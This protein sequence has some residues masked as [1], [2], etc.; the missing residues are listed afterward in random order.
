MV[1]VMIKLFAIR[2]R[3]RWKVYLRGSR[4]AAWENVQA[5]S[6]EP[7]QPLPLSCT[8]ADVTAGRSRRPRAPL[9]TLLLILG[10]GLRFLVFLGA[11]IE[12][13][14]PHLEVIQYIAQHHTLPISNVLNQSYHPPL[15]YVLMAP[16]WALWPSP[17]FIHFFSFV[18]SVINLLLI[19]RLLDHPLIAPD[20]MVRAIAFGFACFN[21]EF[22]MFSGYITNDTLAFLVGT[23]VFRAALQYIQTP[24]SKRLRNLG[25]L[26]GVAML[27]KATFLGVGPCLA[28]LVFLIESRKHT[29]K[30]P[31]V[32]RAL[33]VFC[34]LWLVIGSYKYV[35]NLITHGRPF[36]HNLD[37]HGLTWIMQRPTWRGWETAYDLDIRAILRQ[38]SIQMGNAPSYPLLMYASA[39]YPYVGHSFVLTPAFNNFQWVPKMLYI[40]GIVP[41]LIYLIG[42]VT[43]GVWS[44]REI[45]R[46]TMDAALSQ[47]RL[48]AMASLLMV[49]P[50]V[51]V[52]LAAGVKY[53]V[54]SC[55]Q[56]R[57]CMQSTMPIIMLFALGYDILPRQRMIRGILH[58][59]CWA[60]VG[61]CLLYF[62]IGFGM[63]IRG[64]PAGA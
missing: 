35:E 5:M 58:T 3:I 28:V 21:E 61:A 31:N 39:W 10:I 51:V 55:F 43:G 40:L 45:R 41:T 59:L 47:R 60:A 63:V 54:W 36:V 25:I 29:A 4:L 8:P 49:I 16:L 34:A 6:V 2:G 57:L 11:D 56:S 17:Q 38:P 12:N 32:A 52:V 42:F 23:L 50:N 64:N 44:L 19:R 53:D 1:S 46:P 48:L 37:L 24:D 20:R 13:P 18:L 33:L 26:I 22:V 7:A 14:D 27:T 30:T 62:M 15:Y 9:M